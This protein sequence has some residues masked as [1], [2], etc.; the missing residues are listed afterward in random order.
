MAR[1][2]S[3]LLTALMFTIVSAEDL[4]A[5][6]SSNYFPSQFTCF[7]DNFL[8][9]IV[10]GDRY[11]KCGKACSNTT[12]EPISSPETPQQ[13]SFSTFLPSQEV[14]L[15]GFALCPIVNGTATLWCGNTCYTPSTDMYAAFLF[16]PLLP[17]PEPT[18]DERTVAPMAKCTP[19]EPQRPPVF[20]TSGTIKTALI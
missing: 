1:L 7:D 19:L 4:L 16:I 11:I 14:C 13:C 8:C 17:A 12:L 15:E 3:I 5:C 20:R 6:G 9:P 10:D 18:A 2:I